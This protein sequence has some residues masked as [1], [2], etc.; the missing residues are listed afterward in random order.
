[1]D[2]YRYSKGSIS[3]HKALEIPLLIASVFPITR[4]CNQCRCPSPEEWIRKNVEQMPNRVL[5][6]W[7]EK[8][9][10]KF[11]GNGW[12]WEILCYGGDSNRKTKAACSLVRRCWLRTSVQV[13]AKL[14]IRTRLE[15]E[16]VKRVSSGWGKG[17]YWYEIGKGIDG[18]GYGMGRWRG[19]VGGE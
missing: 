14:K 18:G 15:V 10:M 16:G 13:W 17:T 8:R 12:I 6:S 19:G 4:Q 9:F 7:K 5:L 3:Y 1:M 11:S 2:V